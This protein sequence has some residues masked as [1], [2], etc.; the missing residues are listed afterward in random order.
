MNVAMPQLAVEADA[1]SLAG[2]V[3][4][5]ALDAPKR[6]ILR[7]KRLGL[8][9]QTSGADF[10]GAIV[11]CA[12]GFSALG[13][14]RGE[15][16]GILAR[17]CPE[18]L[19]A[20]LAAQSAGLVSAGF[21]VE[22]APGELAD[23][24]RRCATRLLVVDTL[25]ALETALDLREVVSGLDWIVALDR[26]AAEEFDDPRVIAFDDLLAR[27]AASAQRVEAPWRAGRGSDLA[28]IIPTS[29]LSAPSRG[30]AFTNAALC[31]AVETAGSIA[32]LRAGDERLSLMPA[33]H[34]FE[35]VFGVYAALAAGVIVNFPESSETALADICEL[36]P[37]IIA[38]SPAFW[39]EIVRRLA[40]DSGAAT[41][42]Q[43]AMFERAMRSG[44]IFDQFLLRKVRRDFG[45]SRARIALSAGAPLP[46]HVRERLAGLGLAVSDVYALAEAAGPVAIASINSRTFA[47]AKGVETEIG[48]KGELRLRAVS[49]FAGYAGY[50]PRAEQWLPAGD[51][52]EAGP[53]PTFRL[54]DAACHSIDGAPSGL[55]RRI[56][57]ALAASPYIIASAVSGDRADGLQA[58]LLADFDNLV[59]YAQARAIPFTHYRSLV[60]APQVRALYEQELARIG[61]SFTPA[62]IVSF[63][64]AHGTLSPGDPELGP[65][66]NLRRR[67]L[68][69]TF[70]EQMGQGS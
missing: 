6:T 69:K 59:R 33:S 11:A 63:A 55:V 13:L 41:R 8:W 24:A 22:K 43:R 7:V 2:L 45:L 35:R 65:A 17:P 51:L 52:A 64:L 26:A 42:F 23:L 25:A 27:G 40:R 15:T 47:P 39:S 18:W 4:A 57:D 67:I 68:V 19:V 12:A 70:S 50:P 14:Q 62:R 3:L 29:G 28:A 56:E 58:Y 54:G 66:M 1:E 37:Q 38:A 16:I 48:P 32:D 53:G 34:A 44:G 5:R 49:A 61:A 36:Q 46:P 60:E 20:D 21:H 9:K 31:A 30:A 10:S